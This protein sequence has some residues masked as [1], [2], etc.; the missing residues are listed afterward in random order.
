MSRNDGQGEKQL[1]L[2]Q[3]KQL[4]RL[5]AHFQ[6]VVALRQ[7]LSVR[8]NPNHGVFAFAGL[9]IGQGPAWL[10]ED[11]LRSGD[12]VTLLDEFSAPP[13]PMQIVEARLSVP[14]DLT[15]LRQP[16]R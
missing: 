2:D 1:F 16:S 12:L 10:F 15:F 3:T 7:G 9:G 4:Q 14:F 5:F 8:S 6:H 11:G 13:V